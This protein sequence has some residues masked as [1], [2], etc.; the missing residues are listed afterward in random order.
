[1]G[2]YLDQAHADHDAC[3]KLCDGAWRESGLAYVRQRLLWIAGNLWWW[4]RQVSGD[5]DYENYLRRGS[6]NSGA[7]GSEHR[8]SRGAISAEEFYL[9]NLRRKH[10]RI[11]RCC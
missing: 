2:A 1:V 10:S 5:A 6:R 9:E 4:L 11:N 8:V 3:A 7:G